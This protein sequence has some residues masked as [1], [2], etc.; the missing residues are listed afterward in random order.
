MRKGYAKKR[1]RAEADILFGEG[2]LQITLE[3]KGRV[4]ECF[5]AIS[6]RRSSTG[7]RSS[8]GATFL[9]QLTGGFGQQRRFRKGFVPECISP[10]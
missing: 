10:G 1:S 7:A 9:A 2:V 6:S 4:V 5:F 3:G 8:G